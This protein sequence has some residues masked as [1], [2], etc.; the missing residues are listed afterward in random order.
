MRHDMM[1]DGQQ[2]RHDQILK[3]FHLNGNNFAARS[4]HTIPSPKH[5]AHVTLNRQVGF[6]PMSKP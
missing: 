1:Y 5:L 4:Q 2:D 6:I 3:H